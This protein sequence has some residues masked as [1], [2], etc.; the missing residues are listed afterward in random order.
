M[1]LDGYFQSEKYF[2]KYR[3]KILDFFKMSDTDYN[4]IQQNFKHLLC[5]TTVS[6]HIRRGD[7]TLP[8]YSSHHPVQ[9]IDYYNKAMSY[10]DNRCKLFSI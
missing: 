2:N 6:L 8:Q 7:Y 4:F 3:K 9:S 5:G 10:F 1:C